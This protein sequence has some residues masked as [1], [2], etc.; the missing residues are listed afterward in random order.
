MVIYMKRKKMNCVQES[1]AWE[2]RVGICKEVRKFVL[3][4]YMSLALI[5]VD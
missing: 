1:W 2:E 5:L 3:S 4:K